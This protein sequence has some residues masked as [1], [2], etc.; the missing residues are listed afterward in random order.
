M[1]SKL[2]MKHTLLKTNVTFSPKMLSVLKGAAPQSN[3]SSIK[4]KIQKTKAETGHIN[5]LCIK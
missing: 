1:S 4:W 3:F 5:Y 2:P